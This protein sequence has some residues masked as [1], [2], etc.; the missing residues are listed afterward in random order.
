MW[1]ILFWLCLFLSLSFYYLSLV[2][3]LHKYVDRLEKNA[4]RTTTTPEHVDAKCNKV[5]HLH[6]FTENGE[7][8][9]SNDMADDN[10]G[11]KLNG[12]RASN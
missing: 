7:E 6:S 5:A 3:P 2:S 8:M 10:N 11:K 4:M 9:E 12:K 1:Y